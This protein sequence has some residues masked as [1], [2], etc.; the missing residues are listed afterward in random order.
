M[1]HE[2]ID[3]SQVVG[4]ALVWVGLIIFTIDSVRSSRTEP[5]VPEPATVVS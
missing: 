3:A 1:Y 2:P 4:F 5:S